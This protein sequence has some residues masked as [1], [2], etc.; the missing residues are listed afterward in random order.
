MKLKSVVT[1]EK[2]STNC[3]K[4]HDQERAGFFKPMVHENVKFKNTPLWFV[5]SFDI[6]LIH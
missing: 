2:R 4:L 1:R 5:L 6:L 3:I